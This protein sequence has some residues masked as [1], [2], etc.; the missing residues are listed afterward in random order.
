VENID[1]GPL[2]TGP[3]VVVGVFPDDQTARRVRDQLVREGV[4]PTNVR[5]A[6]AEDKVASLRGEMRESST[7]A[8]SGS[9]SA[10]RA[11]RR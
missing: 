3:D 10:G 9:P 11:R 4:P 5:L 2:D 7:R 6:D 1:V 8:W